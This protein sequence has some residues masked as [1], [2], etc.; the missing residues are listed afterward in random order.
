MCALGDMEAVT[1]LALPAGND[2]EMGGGSFNF[3]TIPDLVEKSKLD[4]NVV[5]TAVARVLTTKFKMGLFEYP[6]TALPIKQANATI[7][8]PKSAALARQ[9]DAESIILLENH[10]KT[11][12]LKKSSKIAVIGP[13]AD[14]V[15]NVSHPF[16]KLGIFSTNT[17]SSTAI[18]YSTNQTSAVSPLSPESKPPL[19]PMAQ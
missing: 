5:N 12:P 14:G 15:M 2:V 7:N 8:T 10:N 19:A 6:Y 4:I 13:M 9:L 3:R 17:I 16:P 18:T 1:T 11:L